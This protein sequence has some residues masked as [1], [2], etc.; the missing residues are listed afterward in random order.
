MEETHDDFNG[1]RNCRAT[2]VFQLEKDYNHTPNR[3]KPE[4][5]EKQTHKVL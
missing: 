1:L 2:K 3:G 4:K 5:E